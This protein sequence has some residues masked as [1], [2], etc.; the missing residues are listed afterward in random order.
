MEGRYYRKQPGSGD[1]KKR[2]RSKGFIIGSLIALPILFYIVFGSHG[3]VQ[4][5]ELET[6]ISDLEE[7]IRVAEFQNEQLKE[8]AKALDSD[9]KAIEKVAREKYA[10]AREGETVYRIKS[11]RGTRL[12]AEAA[13]QA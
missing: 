6:R 12:P 1:L 7:K 10:M 4:R 3:I 9:L 11:E 13:P 2:L 8:L 5:I